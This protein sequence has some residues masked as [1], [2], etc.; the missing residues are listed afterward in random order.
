MGK[1]STY[2]YPVPSIQTR[3]NQAKKFAGMSDN[4]ADTISAMP[5]RNG[6]KKNGSRKKDTS[7][8]GRKHQF[9]GSFKRSFIA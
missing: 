4:L 6:K 5:K 8:R 1:G 3:M 9:L 2:N 7:R